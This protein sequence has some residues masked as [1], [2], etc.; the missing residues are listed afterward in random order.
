MVIPGFASN[1]QGPMGYSHGAVTVNHLG[2]VKLV[3]YASDGHAIKQ[4]TFLNQDGKW[5]FHAPMYLTTNDTYLLKPI[6]RTRGEMMGWLSFEAN[7]NAYLENVN[8][9]PLGK[10]AWI[11]TMWTNANW[12]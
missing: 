8:L 3:G 7:T 5:P 12:A 2:V 6:K 10:V 1:A 9:A 11:K 4:T